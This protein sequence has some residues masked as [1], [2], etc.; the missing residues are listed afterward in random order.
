[1]LKSHKSEN[2]NFMGGNG[3]RLWSI[4]L[5]V[6]FLGESLV[7]VSDFDAVLGQTEG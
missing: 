3:L 7:L 1:M 5:Y 2:Q 6:N 4:Y